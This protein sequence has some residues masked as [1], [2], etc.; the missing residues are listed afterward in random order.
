MGLKSNQD[1]LVASETAQALW[2]VAP[3]RAEIRPEA[4][5]L[6]GDG[7]KLHFEQPAT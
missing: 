3:G 7:G 5:S 1:Q 4:L 2:Y 6:I